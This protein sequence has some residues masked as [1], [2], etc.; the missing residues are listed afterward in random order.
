MSLPMKEDRPYARPEDAASFLVSLIIKHKSE[1][2]DYA[3]VGEVNHAF[4][5]GGGSVAEYALGRD[6][7]I[8]AGWITMHESGCRFLL[9]ETQKSPAPA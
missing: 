5:A 1:Y 4:T 6:C 2:G 8:E 7:A 9:P 3:N